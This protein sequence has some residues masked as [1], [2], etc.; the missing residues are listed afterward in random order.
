MHIIDDIFQWF[1]KFQG[2]SSSAQGAVGEQVLSVFPLP[3]LFC[4][5]EGAIVLANSMFSRYFKWNNDQFKGKDFLQVLGTDIKILESG[6]SNKEY[7]L[8][9]LDKILEG[10]N[11]KILKGNFSKIGKRV[12]NLYTRRLRIHPSHIL[13]IFEDVSESKDLE[14]KIIK[15][16]REL[17]SLFDG[18]EDP[19]VMIDENYRIRRINE[20]MLKTVGG[21]SYQ[22]FIGKAC[23]YKLHG[24]REKCPGCTAEKTFRTGKKTSRIGLVQ[25]REN[26][27][28][29][30]YQITCYPLKDSSF[31]SSGKVS[32]I[33]E[34]YHDMTEVKKI[35]EELYESERTRIIEPLAVGIAHEV[36]NP[37]AIIRSTAQ[38]CLGEL[39]PNRDL[40]ESLQTIVKSAETANR[41]VTDLLDFARPPKIDFYM[42]PLKPLL[43]QGL[44]LLKTRIKDQKIRISKRIQKIPPLLLD[45]GRFLQAFMNILVNSL[46][47]MPHGG[48]LE[49]EASTKS[50][51]NGPGNRNTCTVVIRDSGNGVP[52]EM[53]SQL[54]QPFYSTK[55]EGVGLGLPIAEGI[56]RSHGGRINFKSWEGKGSETT[57]TLPLRKT[58]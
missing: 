15:S 16:R 51:R 21:D 10:R 37:L 13:L 19:T 20:A 17:L 41:V 24:L 14:G 38:Y 7:P 26:A 34:S 33:A 35:E 53:V 2:R 31:D 54:F 43:E 50:H 12:F 56:I 46:D 49:V 42:K 52:E 11:P 30:T 29:F 18:M 3:V 45:E 1:E 57:L 4:D 8:S 5:V 36:R 9:R 58:R 55:K 47:A 6:G 44:R 39:G 40:R 27:E 32:A 48:R 23:Y 28:D 25:R 22:N